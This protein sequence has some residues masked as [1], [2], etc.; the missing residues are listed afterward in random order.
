MDL[1][2]EMSNLKLKYATL[3]KEKK[4]TE[5][6]LKLSQVLSNDHLLDVDTTE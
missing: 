3:E 6:K 1:M 2:A 4:E 5:K